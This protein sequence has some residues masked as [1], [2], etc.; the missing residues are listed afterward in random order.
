MSTDTTLSQL[1]ATPS[2]RP[3]LPPLQAGDRLTQDEFRRRYE[4][5]PDVDHAELI[6]GVV[7]MPSP[8]S[9]DGHGEPHI[10]VAAWLGV[11]MAHTPG[12]RAGDNSTLWLDVDNAPQPDCY[13]R[14]EEQAGG[15]SRLIDGYIHGAPEL[16][17]EVSA[18][19]VSYDLHD[20]LTSYRR[21]GVREYVVWRVQD[22]ELDWFVL[23]E[24]RFVRAEA[25]EDGIYRSEVF[26]GL[27]L[28]SVSLIAGDLAKVLAV[29][30]AGLD[31]ESHQNDLPAE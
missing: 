19:T 24:G 4:A 3:S 25:D 13:L 11:Y 28:D 15:Q 2:G 31:S 18:S 29:L 20:K 9:A 16:V 7:Y 27:W 8:V 5:M 26:A 10:E 22:R 14:I 12:V 21:N 23:R 30:Q 1:P 17:V 6:E